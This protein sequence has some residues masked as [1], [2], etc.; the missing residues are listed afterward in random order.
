MESIESKGQIRTVELDRSQSE[1]RPFDLDSLIL[2]DHPARTIWKLSTELKFSLFEQDV[3]SREGVAGRP[4]WPPQLLFSMW[5]YAYTQGVASARAIERMMR[6]EPGM[7]WLAADQ[8]INYH[9]ISDFRVG[10]EEALKEM[11]AQFLAILETA[12][13][14]DLDTLLVDGT[15][16]RA[17]AGRAS[18]RR[19]KTVEKRLR[20][21]RRVV[22]KLDRQAASESE[23]MDGKHLAA[24]RRAAREALERAQAA[25]KKLKQLEADAAPSKV[26][27]L[28]VSTSEA[29]ARNMKHPDGGWGPSYNV[30]VTTEAQSRM[31]VGVGVTTA[32]NDTQELIPALERAEA[33]C[34]SL[35][36]QVIADN[37]YAT[38][39]NVEQCSEKNVTVIAP[40]KEDASREAGACAR[41]GIEKGFEPSA[42]RAQYGGKQLTC[43]TGKK[44]VIIGQ[45]TH[46]GV[47][48][49]VFEAKPSDC[50]G[51]SCRKQCCGK[52]GGPRRVTRVVESPAMKEY[53]ARMKRPETKQL[54]KKRCEIAEFPHLWAKAMK[55]WRRFS[56]RGVVKAGMEAMWVALAYNVT[57]WIRIAKP[58]AIPS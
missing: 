42:F 3:K 13:L 8:V 5:V 51:C 30:Q 48:N 38:R 33:T 57:Q 15:K 12:N 36:E 28:Q 14:V 37:G 16:V 17:V 29:E 50:R 40:W 54:Y 39:S 4:C 32:A 21:A 43:P 56:V 46:H 18:L 52:S 45:K 55:K 34:G 1:W 10:H 26:K 49:N 23:E 35:P 27:E 20:K 41:N 58:E 6:Y 24:Q 25:M 47:L 9:T 2:E 11:F 22:K 53:L 7:R 19:H 44:L 31:I